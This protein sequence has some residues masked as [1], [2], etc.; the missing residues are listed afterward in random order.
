MFPP[1]RPTELLI[2]SVCF[3][4][5]LMLPCFVFRTVFFDT[6]QG[7]LQHNGDQTGFNDPDMSKHTYLLTSL[8]DKGT[9]RECPSPQSSVLG[10]LYYFS[11]IRA[12]GFVWNNIISFS[13]SPSDSESIKP[14]IF[15][16]GCNFYLTAYIVKKKRKNISWSNKV[17]VYF[18]SSLWCVWW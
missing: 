13:F 5:N 16:V 14:Q 2:Y 7:S 1:L 9:I 12:F 11:S 17:I 3:W 4:L 18:I 8:Q 10:N 6:Q 15:P